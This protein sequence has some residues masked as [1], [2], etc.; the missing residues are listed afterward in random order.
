MKNLILPFLFFFM[1]LSGQAQTL[2]KI[3]DSIR[4]ESDIPEL[5]YGILSSDSILVTNMLGYHRND[6]QDE[7]NKAKNTDYFHLGSNTKAITSFIAGYLVEQKKISWDTK[8]F[9]LFP[10]LKKDANPDFYTMTLADLLS[11]RARIKPYT[12]GE[13]F[14]TL[15]LFV[16]LK[17]EQ[18]KQFV[19]YLVKNDALPKNNETYNY[20]NAG[21][22]IAARMLEKVSGRTWEQLL[23]DVLSKKLGLKYKLGWPNR[24]DT[25]QP[26]GHWM[27]NDKLVAL[28]PTTTYD[29]KLIEPAGDISMPLADYAKFIRLNLAGLRGRNNLLKS[30]TYNFLHFGREKY[31]MGWL[32]INS[33]GRHA[34]EHAGSAGTFYCYT[35]INKDK[36]IAYIIIANCA[37]E[38]ALKG[39]FKLLDKMVKSAES[40]K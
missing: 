15:P 22:S 36:N 11:H 20:S 29:L 21:F 23:D 2:S 40:S 10:E 12:S 38:N 37:T 4:K 33:T 30:E 32:N 3:A 35:L 24:T 8:F 14:Q 27:E 9:T 17:A 26:W 6:L 18:R 5:A 13:E 25:D 1:V 39:I 7:K 19:E 16:G 34:S 31:A 28:P